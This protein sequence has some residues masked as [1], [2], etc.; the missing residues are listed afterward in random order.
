MG[1]ICAKTGRNL[2]RVNK[3]SIGASELFAGLPLLQETPGGIFHLEVTPGNLKQ[4]WRLCCKHNKRAILH[5]N[6]DDMIEDYGHF[7]WNPYHMNAIKYLYV[8]IKYHVRDHN[9]TTEIV[10]WHFLRI[11]EEATNRKLR[12]PV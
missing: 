5:G 11:S 6:L 3:R 12:G 8:N 2:S 10:L 9:T 1:L 4:D 7:V